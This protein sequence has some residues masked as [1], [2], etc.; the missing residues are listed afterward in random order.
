MRQLALLLMV[1]LWGGHAL[2]GDFTVT[3]RGADG[4]PVPDA[5]V[6]VYPNGQPTRGPIKFPWPYRVAQQN[7][8]FSPFML[9]V[10]VG[11]DVSFPN[12]DKVRH[13]V[14]SFSPGNRFEIKLYGH[15]ENRTAKMS[16]VGAVA[17]GCNIHD[18]MVGFIRVVDTQYAGKTDANGVVA[19]QDVPAGAVVARVWHPYLRA[20]KNEKTLATT[21]LGVGAA[22]EAV[23]IDLRAPSGH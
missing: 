2:A 22:R 4:K 21:S 20:M 15:E 23:S 17:I 6:S 7:I 12:L 16:A 10:P 1:A 8:Q 11:A 13:H 9:V 14:Y 5:V 19:I 18:Q 3:V